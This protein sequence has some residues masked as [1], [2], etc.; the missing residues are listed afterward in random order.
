MNQHSG[1]PSSH[2]PPQTQKLIKETLLNKVQFIKFP[3]HLGGDDYTCYYHIRNNV[4]ILEINRDTG[5]TDEGKNFSFLPNVHTTIINEIKNN[6]EE[7]YSSKIYTSKIFL[8]DYA[9]YILQGKEVVHIICDRF[10]YDTASNHFEKF[11]QFK[12]EYLDEL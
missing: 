4:Y 9:A 8:I 1:Y 11:I 7:K 3:I 6:L 10:I 5:S 12:S 2:I